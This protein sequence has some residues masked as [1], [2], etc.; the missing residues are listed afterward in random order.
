MAGFFWLFAISAFA[1]DSQILWS[2][3]AA[4]FGASTSANTTLT[5][6]VGQPLVGATGDA[7]TGIS[8]GFLADT[9]FTGPVTGVEEDRREAL[10]GAYELEQ[11]YPNPFNPTTR[12]Q[13]TLPK[14]SAVRLTLYDLL[15]REVVTLVDE[16]RVAGNHTIEW[17][18]FNALGQRVGSGVYF[19]R[20]EA[21]RFVQSRK[22]M[23]LK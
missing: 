13:F 4:G 2:A 10:P 15:G 11:N 17:N 5:S 9:T 22:L 23:L 1:Q 6:A 7:N 14:R 20:I 12:I 18:G 19:Y 3:F 21:G 16:V 8:S